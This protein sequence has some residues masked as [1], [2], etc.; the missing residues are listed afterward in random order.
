MLSA[1]ATFPSVF[2]EKKN[3]IYVLGGRYHEVITRK[4][5]KY[6]LT[7]KK[8]ESLPLKEIE[9]SR[10]A[11]IPINDEKIYLVAMEYIR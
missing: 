2:I 1:R 4:C 9:H 11:A 10:S 6:S 5:E 3:A 7:S 8:W